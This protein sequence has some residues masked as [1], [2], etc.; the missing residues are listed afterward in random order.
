MDTIVSI[1]T[2]ALLITAIAH[3]AWKMLVDQNKPDFPR[4]RVIV[5]LAASSIYIAAAIVFYASAV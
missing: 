4:Q 2:L 1:A 5:W 3:L